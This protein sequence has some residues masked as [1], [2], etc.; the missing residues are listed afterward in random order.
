MYSSKFLR[1]A[2]I[3]TTMEYYA[4]IDSAAEDAIA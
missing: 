2:D 3:S 1:H 4:D